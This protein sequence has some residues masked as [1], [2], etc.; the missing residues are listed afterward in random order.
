MRDVKIAKELVEMQKKGY[1]PLFAGEEKILGET[2]GIILYQEQIDYLIH[3]V[4]GW[5]LAESDVLRRHMEN[6]KEP[7]ISDKKKE[8]IKCAKEKGV[9]R[10]VADILYKK[11]VASSC[12]V[13][14]KAYCIS[15]TEMV[16]KEAYLRA[17]YPSAFIS[18]E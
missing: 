5:S 8:F 18:M 16:W 15:T 14:N 3:S 1:V 9:S 2:Y 4:T 6:K 12:Y 17:H 7:E 13:E 11:I 10:V